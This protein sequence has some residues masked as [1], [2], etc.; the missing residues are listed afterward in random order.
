MRV[1]AVPAMVVAAAFAAVAVHGASPFSMCSRLEERLASGEGV[2]LPDADAE[3]VRFAGTVDLAEGDWPDE[4]R[5]RT[6]QRICVAVSPF[7]GCYEFFGESGEVFWTV[8]PF[9]PTTENWVA[10]FR[11][12]EPGPTPDDALY[13]SWRL[14]DVWLLSHA[15][16]A[17]LR[18]HAESAELAELRFHAENT[19]SL[20]T[21]HS[22]LVTRGAAGPAT[23]LCFTAFSLAATNLFFAAAW[24][25]NET[26]PENVL[27]LYGTS[28]L[29]SRTWMFLSSHPATNTPVSFSVDPATLP[30]SVASTQHVHD[31][32]C[33]SVTNVVVSPFDGITAYTNVFWSC[34][35]NRIPADI[36]F[37]RLGTRFDGDGDGLA[38]ALEILVYGTSANAVDTDGDGLPDGE[39][40]RVGTD[41]LRA[42]TD[43]DGLSDGEETPRI[44]RNVSIPWSVLAGETVLSTNADEAVFT[45]GTPR[46]VL[47]G[48]TV[49]NITV[50][51]NGIVYPRNAFGRSWAVSSRGNNLATSNSAFHAHY[52][53]VAAYWDD[54]RLRP[55]LGSRLVTGTAGGRFVVRWDGAGF[56]NAH[57]ATNAVSFQVAFEDR[58]AYATYGTLNDPLRGASATFAA[59]GPGAVPNLWLGSN[60]PGI[61]SAGETVGYF[62]GTGSSPLLADT[63]GDGLPDGTEISLG[64]DPSSADTDDDDLPDAWEVSAGLDPLDPTGDNGALGDPDG[65]GQ[66]NRQE[67][68]AGTAPLLVDTD[69]DG[70]PDGIGAYSWSHHSLQPTASR[71]ANLVVEFDANVPAGASAAFR[72]GT[73]TVPLTNGLHA[74]SFHLAAGQRYDFR[75]CT[76]GGASV[77]AEIVPP[78]GD[79]PCSDLPGFTLNDPQGGFSHGRGTD[80]HGDMSAP[81]L[82]LRPVGAVGECVHGLPGK[83]TW[84]VRATPGSWTAYASRAIVEGFETEGGGNVSLTVADMPPSVV[85]GIVSIA[86]TEPGFP[87]ATVFA[88]I[89]RCEYDYVNNRC[90]WCGYIHDVA[91]LSISIVADW[92]YALFGSTN[93]CGFRAVGDPSLITNVIWTIS[94]APPDGAW[95]HDEP[96]F[97]SP[98]GTTLEHAS[99]IWVSAGYLTNDYT[100]TASYAFAPNVCAVEPFTA[101]AI[102]AEAICAEIDS[103]G[104]VVNP[105]SIPIGETATFRVKVFPSS[106]PNDCIEWRIVNGTNCMEFA[107]TCYGREVKLRGTAIGSV[108]L[109]VH[110]A[111]YNGL[112]PQF[113]TEVMPLYDIPVVAWIVCKN[114]G[115]EPATSESRI[116]TMVDQANYLFRQVCI[117]CYVN[118]INYT[119]ND[120]WLDLG[121]WGTQS[122]ND[123]FYEMTAISNPVG[124]IEV[125][126][127]DDMT[128]VAG[129][130]SLH[131][132]VL[133]DQ[134]TFTTFTH[135]TGHAMGL[136]DI[137]P[138]H[139]DTPLVVT[140]DVRRD[141]SS[142]DWCGDADRGFYPDADDLSQADLIERLVMCGIPGGP[143]RDFS[144]GNLHGIRR[145]WVTTTS[146]EM[147]D[148]VSVGVFP[149]TIPTIP[150]HD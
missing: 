90:D 109:E 104:F 124:G 117:S 68:Q 35:T 4:F 29:S 147:A 44:L 134:A 41:P 24:P 51:V 69:G 10:P 57:Y 11:H 45:I 139:R 77:T 53:S 71:P 3:L 58:V 1:R 6:G 150:H 107:G 119:N 84:S 101:V 14:V 112:V 27:D 105:I 18:S 89:H 92:R 22:S 47:G 30:W 148:S 136:V 20:V 74:V 91:D 118:Q 2:L 145:T 138:R 67:W 120:D 140:G 143:R 113:Q 78:G 116:R 40:I 34:T 36:A 37:F 108:W 87:P 63:D 17:E 125:H 149:G 46:F 127:V 94:P 31:A 122:F 86:S 110:I 62:F 21:R 59:Q 60:E 146:F 64:T 111:G 75:F 55:V 142:C 98:V 72:L 70:I 32:T 99:N 33:Q 132:M 102:D 121:T 106:V 103:D 130:N 65:D 39:E 8:V 54:L 5:T 16:S 7:T 76:T 85:T 126:F 73:L 97:L 42:D 23:N 9:S 95:L 128:D 88:E 61:V 28:D 81:V 96:N 115:T 79:G 135:E 56:Y 38:N 129:A 93:M 100:V 25:T 13:E 144:C 114:D 50:D 26:L 83:R 15:E 141:W 52:P 43:G 66:T 137:Y 123:K 131:G 19:G 49:T 133:S 48:T 80:A 82:S 12:A